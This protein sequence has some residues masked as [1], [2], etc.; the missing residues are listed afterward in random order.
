MEIDPG[1]LIDVFIKLIGDNEIQVTVQQSAKGMAITGVCT[2]LGGLMAGPAGLAV[3]GASGG[4]LSAWYTGG[5]FKSVREVYN[6]LSDEKKRQI[7]TEFQSVVSKLK[8]TDFAELVRLVTVHQ[9]L[10]QE[11]PDNHQPNPTVQK[12]IDEGLL[13]IQKHIQI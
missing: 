13:I 9:S 7:A 3:G 12:L 2:F 8:I 6:E 5:T 4:L 11:D 10:T 1:E